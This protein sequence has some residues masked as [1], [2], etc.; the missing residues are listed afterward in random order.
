MPI[1][2]RCRLGFDVPEGAPVCPRC[3]TGQALPPIIA[4][5]RLAVVLVVCCGLGLVIYWVVFGYSGGSPKPPKE[6]KL[7]IESTPG[8]LVTVFVVYKD[9]SRTSV[10]QG[11]PESGVLLRDLKGGVAFYANVF[12]ADRGTIILFDG[13]TE[14]QRVT[15]E[16]MEEVKVFAGD[17]TG[18]FNG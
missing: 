6:P 2:A 8:A 11:M 3:G 7:R 4:R 16:G 1:C 9:G 5:H 14:I 13:E 17:Q 18:S 12:L 15:T 10:S